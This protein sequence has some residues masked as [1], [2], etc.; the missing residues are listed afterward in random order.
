MINNIFTNNADKHFDFSKPDDVSAQF[1]SYCRFDRMKN[2]KNNF[3]E[4]KDKG[5]D[6][7]ES[8]SNIRFCHV[9]GGDHNVLVIG[10]ENGEH[11]ITKPFSKERPSKIDVDSN[12]KRKATTLKSPRKGPRE[13]VRSVVQRAGLLPGV[14]NC[15]G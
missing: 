6:S 5:S 10:L 2:D 1:V 8:D 13:Y 3:I 7:N 9:C 15:N 11:I 14:D 12:V 4:D